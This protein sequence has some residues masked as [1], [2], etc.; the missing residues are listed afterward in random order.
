MQ[1]WR[2]DG[3]HFTFTRTLLSASDR[4]IAYEA[5]AGGL[6]VTIEEVEL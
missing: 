4:A 2:I 1:P 6:W 3:Y 5:L